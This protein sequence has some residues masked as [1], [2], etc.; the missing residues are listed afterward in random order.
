MLDVLTLHFVKPKKAK[1]STK[2]AIFCVPDILYFSQVFS[3]LILHN[4]FFRN[5][6]SSSFVNWLHQSCK[7]LVMAIV[8]T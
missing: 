3:K 5:S 7:W 2:A 4:R 1:L 8:Q 6:V